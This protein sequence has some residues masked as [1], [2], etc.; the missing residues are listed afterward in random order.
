MIKRVAALPGCVV[1][2]SVRS[3]VGGADIVPPE[4]FVVLGDGT[5]SGDSRR[6]VFPP[7]ALPLAPVSRKLPGSRHNRT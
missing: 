4:M 5:R 1:P 2:D 6:W 3:A 7:P